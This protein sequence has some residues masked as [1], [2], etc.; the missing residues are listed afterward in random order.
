MSS[1]PGLGGRGLAIR[2]QGDH[3]APF[4]VADDVGVSVIA[5][6][7]IDADDLERIGRR[8]AAASDD[9]GACLCLLA[10][11]AVLRSPRRSIAE[12]QTQVM[13]DRVQ[14]RRASRRWSQYPIG[15]TLSEDLPSAQD[16]VAAEAVGDHQELY[17]PA[18]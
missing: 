17:D 10:A 15:E 12:R 8:T 4:Q 6:P 7:V 5:P 3:P 18:G 9:A 14:P 16:G 2:Q 13:D 1:Q 11:S